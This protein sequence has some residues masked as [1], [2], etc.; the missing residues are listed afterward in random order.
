MFRRILT[1]TGWTLL[2]GVLI[3]YFY[4]AEV[5]QRKNRDKE[6]CRSIT[7]TLLDSARN[8]FVTAEEVKKIITDFSGE[9]IGKK[10]RDIDIRNIEEL[11]NQRSAIREAQVSL[12]RAGDMRIDITQRRPVLRIE[13]ENGGFY[14]DETAY[15][16]P[17]VETFTSYVPVVTGHIPLIINA[18]HRG[19]ALEDETSWVEKILEFGKFVEDNPFWSA[20]IEQI[21]IDNNGDILLS[22][23]TGSQKIIFGDLNDIREKFRKLYAFYKDVVPEMGWDKYG[24]V[25]LKYKNQIVCKLNGR[26]K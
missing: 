6:I 3:S 10:N 7:V 2:L 25:N 16:F 11:L 15:I 1:Y 17:W 26:G 20:Q 8:R 19:R 5:L 24:T 13:T 18:G 21:Y 14:I 4:F 22:P 9:I 12:S 23:R